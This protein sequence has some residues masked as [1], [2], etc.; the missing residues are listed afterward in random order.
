MKDLVL[1]TRHG[2][3]K[4][5][6]MLTN[7]DAAL[8]AQGWPPGCQRLDIGTLPASDPRTGYPT[9]TLL[10]QGNDVFGMPVP[11]PPFDVPS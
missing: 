8:E 4:T 2:C 5:A 7:L 3:R 9:P 1:L 6:A 11:Q 10:Y